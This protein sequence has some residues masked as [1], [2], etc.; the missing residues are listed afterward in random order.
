[1]GAEYRKLFFF[2]KG[3]FSNFLFFLP[4]FRSKNSKK[5]LQN[6]RGKRSRKK[7]RRKKLTFYRLRERKKEKTWE[8]NFHG[9]IV[10]LFLVKKWK[11]LRNWQKTFNTLG[12]VIFWH[13][14][15]QDGAYIFGFKGMVLVGVLWPSSAGD[16]EKY[17]IDTDVSRKKYI[18]P[19]RFW[20][21]IARFCALDD[22]HIWVAQL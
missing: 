3:N 1:M 18:I 17:F 5:K 13:I 11:S 20:G 4:F 22:S 21:S 8:K 15:S 19:R 9:G 10:W 6:G 2:F 16:N 14:S 7:K 12:Q